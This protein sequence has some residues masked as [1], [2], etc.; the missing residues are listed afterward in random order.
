MQD[1]PAQNTPNFSARRPMMLGFIALLV[2]VGGFGTWAVASKLSGAVIAEGQVQIDQNRKVVQ[3]PD[4]GVVTEILIE[5]GDTVAAGDVLIRLDAGQLS[6]QLTIIEG[7]YFE[8]LARQ[9]RFEAERDGADALVFNTELVAAAED[10]PEVSSLMNGQVRLFT[11]R[12]EGISTQLEQLEKRK[13]QISRQL[14]GLAA[15]TTALREQLVLIREELSSQQ[16]LLDKGLSQ[17]SRVLALKREEAGI[18]GRLGE[19]SASSAEAELRITETELQRIALKTELREKAITELRDSHASARDLAEQ[20]RNIKEQ[21]ERL[22]IR[23]PVAGVIYGLQVFAEQA[24]IQRAQPVLYVVPQDRDLVIMSRVDPLHI[25]QIFV[26]Q[27]VYLQFP[28]FNSRDTPDLLGRV[29]RMSADSFVDETS[30]ISF[31]QAEVQLD[32]GQ[33]ERLPEG[34]I[35]M[36]GMPVSA[37]IR[38]TDRSPMHYLVEPL[39][40]Y[41]TKAFRET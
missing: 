21:L 10:S 9:A 31:Y 38:T 1:S 30:G 8:L 28:A 17:A 7:Q 40:D 12:M 5:E 3:H 27:T 16:A 33:I 39:W 20:R 41:F 11:S 26:G 14:D 15:Q 29:T 19:L 35:L 6:S 22:E 36:P 32:E 13:T 4:G 25:D 23:A 37:F 24:V 2:L 34:A 18:L